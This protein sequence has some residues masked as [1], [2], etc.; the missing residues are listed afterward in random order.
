MKPRT[1]TICILGEAWHVPRGFGRAYVR[2]AEA[3]LALATACKSGE[4]IA[5]V[6]DLLVLVGYAATV[7]QVADWDLRRRV[8]AVVYAGTE[9]AR[10]SDNPVPRHPRPSWLP[11]RPW[12]GPERGEGV[13]AGPTGTQIVENP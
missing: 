10:A 4:V 6:I 9:H 13:F 1:T 11:E 2:A 12:Q 5:G 8:E 3:D 7:E